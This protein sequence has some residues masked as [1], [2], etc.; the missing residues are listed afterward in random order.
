[1]ALSRKHTLG[2]GHVRKARTGFTDPAGALDQQPRSVWRS[3]LRSVLSYAIVATVWIFT[4]DLITAQFVISPEDITTVS[5]VKGVAF[6]WVTSTL[7]FV[8]VRND[9]RHIHRT[10]TQ[11]RLIA[12]GASALRVAETA[13]EAWLS[14]AEVIKR[15]T[16]Y[17]DAEVWVAST[18]GDTLNL[19]DSPTAGSV[20]TTSS[21]TGAHSRHIEEDDAPTAWLWDEDEVA[22]TPIRRVAASGPLAHPAG[23][24]SLDVIPVRGEGRLVGAILLWSKE[25]K[26]LGSA[27]PDPIRHLVSQLADTLERMHLRADL[28]KSLLYDE[29][30]GLPNRTLLVD[31]LRS[32]V[33][34]ASVL[35]E[36]FLVLVCQVDLFDRIQ[37]SL[38]HDQADLLLVEAS[39]RLS[40]I[41]G[42]RDT[43]ARS[44]SNEFTIV[45]RFNHR[46]EVVEYLA[47]LRSATQQSVAL[48]GGSVPLSISTGVYVARGDSPVQKVLSD[49][50]F[51]LHRAHE[52]GRGRTVFF[53][54]GMRLTIE[55]ALR[56]EV[57]LREALH[58]GQFEVVYQ[59]IVASATRTP[60]GAEAL[61]RWRHPERGLISPADFIPV[62]EDSG[63]IVEIGRHVLQAACQACA[64][65]PITGGSPQSVSVNLS[66]IEFLDPDL[67]AVIQAALADANLS[68][69]RLTIE[70]TETTLMLDPATA[71][72]TLSSLRALG[73]RVAVDDFGTGYS[74]LAY[75]QQFELDMLKIDAS[76]VADLPC[77]TENCAIASAI[78]QMAHAL[79]LRTTAEGV[80]TEEQAAY[81]AAQNCDLLQGY[82]LAR[83]MS[84]E[85]YLAW[86]QQYAA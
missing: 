57:D 56:V 84:A 16:G 5:I 28:E 82:L 67:E 52:L 11:Q 35:D 30:T 2:G 66:A 20:L 75:L 77:S 14:V 54:E 13:E 33:R 49:V 17:E 19:L 58:L 10:L 6:V 46:A 44:Q 81:L 47:R 29:L 25:R 41:L 38:G 80:E 64:A 45:A 42:E 23:Y 68:P 21:E 74:S 32:V 51:A 43:L 34:D 31:R 22:A 7:L 48:E 27:F 26:R 62:A 61:V 1:M 53:D 4:S 71:R 79:N 3:T 70:I 39:N 72:T 63:L 37:Q 55:D 12:Q 69:N 59:P 86:T 9:L 50:A 18:G 85:N 8:L 24:I 83:P 36:E 15:A 60:I 76:F 78:V 40:G 73:V 65:W